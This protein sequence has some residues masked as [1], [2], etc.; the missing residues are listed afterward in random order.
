MAALTIKDIAKIC[1]V[2]ISTVSR[3]MNND[4]GINAQTKERVLRVVKEFNYIP[5]NSARNLKMQ[6]SNT[7]ALLL[8]GVSNPFFYEMLPD[9]QKRLE[10]EGYEYMIHVADEDGDEVKIAEGLAKEKR[11]KGMILLGGRFDYPGAELQNIRI[12]FVLVSVASSTTEI[13]KHKRFNSVSI[14]DRKESY[15]VIDYLAKKGHRHIAIISGR[16]T[17]DTVGSLRLDGYKAAL[18]DNGLPFEQRLVGYMRKDIPEYTEANGYAVAKALL[19]ENKDITAIFAISDRLAIGVY[20][21]I[22]DAGLRIP[23]DISVVG[24]DG[25]EMTRYTIPSMTTV[26][27]PKD[28]MVNSSVDLL[29]SSIHGDETKQKLIYDAELHERDSVKALTIE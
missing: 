7:I 29:M 14:D 22:A 24:F 23:D 21:A 4:P 20:K 2:S 18:A 10:K 6:E 3:A 9:F 1:N 12:P 25:I 28:A 15:K 8:K 17:D 27:Q 19:Q 26:K 16:E 5:N 11:L 13:S